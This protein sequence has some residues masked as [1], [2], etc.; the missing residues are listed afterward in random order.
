MYACNFKYENDYYRIYI[1]MGSGNPSA[2]HT[3]VT[4]LPSSDSGEPSMDTVLGGERAE[5][6]NRISNNHLL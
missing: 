6:E 5:S 3:S 2:E 1:I 4:L